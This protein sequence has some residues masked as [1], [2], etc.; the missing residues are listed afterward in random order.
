MSMTHIDVT[1]KLL[2][3]AAAFFRNLGNQNKDITDQMNENADIF[4]R[5]ADVLRHDPTG[6]I[7]QEPNNQLAGRLLADAARF[8]HEIAEHNEPIKEQMH[9][10]ADVYEKMSVLVAQH[11]METI[12][13]G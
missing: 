6:M 10:N 4:L 13:E 3:D 11:P 5:M 8:F 1:I 2:T 9:Q 12:A 7:E